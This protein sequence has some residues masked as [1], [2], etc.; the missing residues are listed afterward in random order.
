MTDLNSYENN[1]LIDLIPAFKE[2]GMDL[3]LQRMEMALNAMGNPCK[4]IPAIQIAGTN[5][6]GS[7]A[8]FLKSSLKIIRINT[9]FTISPHLVSWCERISTTDA[10]I[11]LNDFRQKIIEIKP[12]IEKYRLTPFEIVIAAALKYFKYKQVDL[13]VLE[14]G[15]GGRLDATTAHPYRPI[16]AFG[17]IGLDHCEYLGNSIEEIAKEKASVIQPKSIVISAKQLPEVENVL[18][19]IAKQNKA[20]LHFVDPLPQEWKLG[21]AGDIQKDN[22]AVAKKVLE[23][24]RKYGWSIKDKDIRKGLEQAKWPGRLEKAKW[25]DISLIIDCAHNPHATEQLSHEREKWKNQEDGIAWILAIQ[26]HKDAPKMLKSL[27]KPPDIVWIVPVPNC[28][29]WSQEELSNLCPN[30][31]SQLKSAINVEQALSVLSINHQWPKSSPVITGSIYLIGD[32]IKK[33]IINLQ[34]N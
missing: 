22:A 12:I 16:I 21:L 24:L 11:T 20:S 8:S 7:I 30:Y 15:L 25:K 5:G 2:R 33:K 17:A 31:S 23:A 28:T 3:N 14:I 9:G 6:K 10:I 34:R 26:K 13:L 32:L 4:S 19:C 27:L 29:S 18:E 1:E